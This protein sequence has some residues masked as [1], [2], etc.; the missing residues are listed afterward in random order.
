MSKTLKCS[1]LALMLM[2]V[3]SAT[4]LPQALPTA[5]PQLLVIFR[6]QIKLGHDAAHTRTESGWPAAFAEA[7]SPDYYLAM[8]SMTGPSEV[9]FSVPWASN[10][11]WGEA[12]DRDDR[13][14]EVPDVVKFSLLLRHHGGQCDDR[15]E[16]RELGRLELGEAQVDPPLASE[17]AVADQ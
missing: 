17:V 8:A 9:W 15:G 14:N 12:N 7:G 3:W 10:A 5:Q 2:T 16:L 13:H 6:E 4:A 11:A 1:V